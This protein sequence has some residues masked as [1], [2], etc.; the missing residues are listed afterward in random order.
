MFQKKKKTNLN[1]VKK[2]IQNSL[3]CRDDRKPVS[4]MTI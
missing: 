2:V 4:T 3:W 1:S